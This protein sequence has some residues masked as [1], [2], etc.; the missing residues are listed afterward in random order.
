MRTAHR[1]RQAVNAVNLS[2]GFGLLLA[3]TAA[4]GSRRARRGPDGLLVAGGYR[5]PLPIAPAFTVGNVVLVRGDASRLDDES[6]LLRHEGRHAT[7]YAWCL[8]L[9]MIPLYGV[10]AGVS[11]LLCGDWASYN[12]FE[13]LAGL[14]D[15]GYE[16]RP[17]RGFP[18]APRRGED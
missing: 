14:A 12:P 18:R 6:R 9:V 1:L 5:L 15:G 3:A 7:Q 16:R 11:M 17:L 2:T 13:R 10:C 8:G 4:R